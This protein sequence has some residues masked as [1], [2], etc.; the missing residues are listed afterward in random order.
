MGDFEVDLMMGSNHKGA[1]LVLTDR[2]SLHTRLAKI[3]SKESGVVLTA[4]KSIL[5]RN[6]HRY[7][8]L[9]SIMTKPLAVVN[10][11]PNIPELKHTLP[12]HTQVKIKR[13]LKIGLVLFA[14]SFQRK[15]IFPLLQMNMS[16]RLKTK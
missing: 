11:L 10:L 15:L 7:G 3:D 13:R 4:M 9:L 8:H 16:V 1:L 5:R 2:T 12:G 6:K 14:D